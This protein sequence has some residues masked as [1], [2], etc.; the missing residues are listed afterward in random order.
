VTDQHPAP[1][2]N[3]KTHHSR[4][5]HKPWWPRLKRIAGIGFFVLVAALLISQ[6]QKIAWDQVLSS[7]ALYP[8]SAVWTAAGL[9]TA[10]LL[11]YSC[12]DLLGRRYTG[13][14]LA[15]R[16][17]MTTT[18]VSYVFNLNLGSLMGA[19]AMR[20]RLYSRLG[21]GMGEIARVVSFSLLTNWMGYLLLAGLLF[22]LRPPTTPDSWG[23]SRL[24]L[25]LTG[26]LLLA[27]VLTY[28]AAA[29]Y[30]KQRSFELRGHTIELPSARLA[31]LQLMIG[32]SNWLLMAGV[33][34]VLLLH[35]VDLANVIGALLLAAVAGIITH[36]PGNLGVLEAVFVALL[37]DQLPTP[38][39]LAGLVAFRLV[40]FLLPLML[41]FVIF[42]V[43]EVTA[44][45]RQGR[46]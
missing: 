2:G 22:S 39:L 32:A 34:D 19:I 21:L 46:P 31:L 9:T 45:K 24:A 43:L 26:V 7:L 3:V 4:L 44:R 14:Q 23:I 5:T 35:R 17:V 20:Y 18:F 37:S 41:A 27:L 1:N 29:R 8:L 13:H 25:R 11:L 12:F 40:Y 42:V 38:E 15:T 30:F 6:A 16:S 28:L 10:S 33:I 36:I